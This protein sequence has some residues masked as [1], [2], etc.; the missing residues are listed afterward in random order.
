MKL[1]L[2]DLLLDQAQSKIEADNARL[3]QKYQG[4]GLQPKLKESVV[5]ALNCNI[6][7]PL[8]EKLKEIS[9]K[10]GISQ[11]RIVQ[12]ALVQL[13]EPF[14]RKLGKTGAFRRR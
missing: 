13:W 9:L 6:Y 1:D 11:R 5:S 8:H 12:D 10:T 4:S 14:E 3:E 2:R 7:R